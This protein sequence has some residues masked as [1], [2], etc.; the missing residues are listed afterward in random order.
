MSV[1]EAAQDESYVP[2]PLAS[3]ARRATFDEP[4]DGVVGALAWAFLASTLHRVRRSE[5]ALLAV[6]LS[7]VVGH[8][9]EP[10]PALAEAGVSL[11]A[12]ALMYAF[13][14]L[15]DAPLDW[16]NPKK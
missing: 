11:L 12:I 2:P 14:D 10:T 6:N 4:T 16:N 1:P 13:T 3:A 15:C 5:G 7:L 9:G 8:G